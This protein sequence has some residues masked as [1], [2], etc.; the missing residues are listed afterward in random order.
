MKYTLSFICLAVLS[1]SFNVVFSNDALNEPVSKH[2][3]LSVSGNQLVNQDGEP[4]QL[5]G[6]SL[7]WSIWWPQFYNE[8]TVEGIKNGCHSNVVRAPLAIET[9][10]GGYLTDPEG[11]K[12]LIVDVIEAAIKNDIYVIVDWHEEKAETHQAEAID[13]FDQISKTYGSYPNI[14]YE[15]FNEP[16][17][18]SW[19]D[20]LKP[21]HE[22]VIKAIRANDPDNVILVGTP[23]WSQSVD[24]AA[25]D[26]ITD[27]KNILY[28]LHFYAGTHK[29]WLR[30]TAQSALD[31]GIGIFVNEYGTCGADAQGEVDVDETNLWWAWLDENNISYVNYDV[32]DKEETASVV[33]PGTTAENVC[34]EEYLTESG[35]L[36]VAQNKK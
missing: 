5:K 31:S 35:K 14:I 15:T 19:S 17:S 10:S 8:P 22:A 2:G 27:Q 7:A 3:Q 18:Q 34:K 20:T 21:Y 33:I 32:T 36:V 26:P 25:A 12:Q 30:D 9:D 16:T 6:M 1:S 24:A 23:T 28:S 11:Q 13:F 4:V 29:Q